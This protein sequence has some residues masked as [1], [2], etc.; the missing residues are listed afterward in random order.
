[1]DLPEQVIRVDAGETRESLLAQLEAA[2]AQRVLLRVT[3]EAVVPRAIED[4]QALKSLARRRQLQLRIVSPV[5]SVVGLAKIYDI[6]AEF[7]ATVG[8]TAALGHPPPLIPVAG[9]GPPPT[10]HPSPA[11]TAAPTSTPNHSQTASD[12]SPSD[13]DWLFGG[14][15]VETL[16]SDFA[17]ERGR[18]AAPPPELRPGGAGGSPAPD[19]SAPASAPPEPPTREP[20]APVPPPVPA[21]APPDPRPAPRPAA[22]PPGGFTPHQPGTLNAA[23]DPLQD[24]QFLPDWL[25]PT[26]AAPEPEA[27]PPASPPAAP[28]PVVTSAYAAAPTA[29][30]LFAHGPPAKPGA[31][32]V[33]PCPHCGAPMDLELLIQQADYQD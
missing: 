21:P 33:V 7:D 9:L 18:S 3:R 19:S 8:K 2:P 28:P 17:A 14:L 16:E 30:P 11:P 31:R 27:L 1:L 13:N 20:P 15:D 24:S 10:S 12:I 4:F 26:G 23:R 32:W 6:E 29:P 5:A 22:P 25:R